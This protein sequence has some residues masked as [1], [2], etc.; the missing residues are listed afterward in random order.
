MITFGGRHNYHSWI[1]EEAL[2]KIVTK[3]NLILEKVDVLEQ[4][5][6]E[7]KLFTKLDLIIQNQ[8]VIMG[9]QER[10]LAAIAELDSATNE[11]ASDLQALRDQL[12]EEGVS[13]ETLD[14]LDEKIARLKVLGQD[15][16]NPVPVEEPPVEPTPP[17]G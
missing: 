10:I 11:V 4:G 15:P 14:T 13:N 5:D 9:K 3:L 16:E 6:L 2:L 8:N 12:A 7:I 17:E 1:D